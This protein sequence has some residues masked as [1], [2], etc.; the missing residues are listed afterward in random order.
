[1][2]AATPQALQDL[3]GR[4]DADVA[5]FPGGQ[6]RIRLDVRGADAWDA[7]IAR[8]RATL[9][10]ADGHQPDALLAA[11]VPTWQAIASDVRG[12]MQAFRAGKLTV[13]QNLHAGVCFLAATSGMTEKQRLRFGT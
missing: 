2:A 4:Y 3:V 1:M 12:G 10:L 8:R 7:V 5:D 13:R 9:E 6:A 11:D